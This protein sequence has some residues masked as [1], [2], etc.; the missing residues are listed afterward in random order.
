M[1]AWTFHFRT[2]NLAKERKQKQTVLRTNCR[3]TRDK[4]I[5][6]GKDLTLDKAIDIARMYELLQAQVNVIPLHIFYQ[7]GCNNLE[8]TSQIMFCYGGNLRNALKPA[9]TQGHHQFYIV[10]TQTLPALSSCLSLNLIKLILSL[11]EN[12]DKNT[13]PQNPRET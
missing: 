6:E 5:N 10:S 8:Y 13:V 9:H 3:K 7:L 2:I 11:G 1:E 4:L 12:E